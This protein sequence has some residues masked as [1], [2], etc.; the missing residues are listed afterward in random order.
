MAKRR[1]IITLAIVSVLFI[2]LVAMLTIP[3]PSQISV[4]DKIA[5]I[6]IEGTIS[7]SAGIIPGEGIVSPN[8]IIPLLE[9]AEQDASIKAVVLEINSGGGSPVASDEIA[10]KIKTMEKPVV[11]WLGDVGASGAYW[12]ASSADKIVSHP[13]SITCSI[14]AFSILPDLTG[15]MNKTG[16][17][18][19]VVRSG[20]YKAVGSGFEEISDNDKAVF[21]GI[22]D[23]VH[24]TFVQ[25]IAENRDLSYAAVSNIADGRPCLGKDALNYGLVD[26]LGNKQDAIDLAAEL[27]GAEQ[28]E[29]TVLKR[30]TS[31]LQ[32]LLSTNF[33]NA[34]YAIGSGMGNQLK[35]DS[36]GAVLVK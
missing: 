32:E 1:T 9:K 29:V 13:L 36:S 5:L 12:I 24:E 25:E 30:K 33:Q 11:A 17:N 21:Q 6:P 16:I 28:P 14:S 31:V 4:G 2:F 10:A 27:G 20:E 15:L 26:S 35:G 8:E 7:V 18:I 23:S 34:M 3:F 19:T 22:I